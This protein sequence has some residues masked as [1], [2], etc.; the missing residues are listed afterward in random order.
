M[1]FSQASGH[2]LSSDPFSALPTEINIQI[3]K[4][5]SLHDM[6]SA[7]ACSPMLSSTLT[8]N[9]QYILEPHL[10][11]VQL[12]YGDISLFHLAAAAMHLRE[13]H[14]KHDGD[15]ILVLEKHIKPVM[16]YILWLNTKTVEERGDINLYMANAAQD[17]LPEI[18]GAFTMGPW[19]WYQLESQHR[20]PGSL[21]PDKAP[22]GL[23]AAFSDGFLRFDC[24][25]SIFHHK[26][27]SL[28]QEQVAMTDVFSNF[29]DI[30]HH[31]DQGLFQ[32]R[33]CIKDA[34]LNSFPPFPKFDD[35]I[36]RM[37][38]YT[39]LGKIDHRYGEIMLELDRRYHRR[40]KGVVWPKGAWKEYLAETAMINFRNRTPDQEH[41]FVHRLLMQGYPKLMFFEQ[42][43]PESQLKTLEEEFEEL[44]VSNL[45]RYEAWAAY[46]RLYYHN[47]YRHFTLWGYKRQ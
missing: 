18:I 30:L 32:E 1:A 21:W 29:W 31:K 35:E 34:F 37:Y 4:H 17:L 22:L 13:L 10:R 45:R 20:S 41:Y 26:N 7:T 38:P 5:L 3:L 36:L 12:S 47:F 24:Y 46:K 27:Q 44:V 39:I 11:E 40:T 2:R 15:T 43:S 25:R 23:R 16:D 6:R 9:R 42:L 8:G 19:E 14:S 28:F 33:A